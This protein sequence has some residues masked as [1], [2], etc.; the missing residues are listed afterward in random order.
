MTR[1][2]CL[3]FVLVTAAG[4]T[5]SAQSLYLPN[6]ASGVGVAGGVAANEDALALAVQAGYSYRTFIDGGVF[7]RRYAYDNT[8]SLSVSSIGVEPYATVHLLRQSDTVPLSLAATASYEK[9]FFTVQND[10]SGVSIDGWA[11]FVGGYAY[12]HFD[13]RGPWSLTPQVTVGFEHAHT[14][15]GVGLIGPDPYTDS[16]AF[17]LAGNLGYLDRG[18]RIWLANP[19]LSFDDRHATFGLNVGATFPIRRR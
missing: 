1:L 12:R 8:G 16:L 10:T 17:Q 14:T 4:A 18:G 13:L 6:G 19:F 2:A 9:Q 5:A 11:M 3:T 7:V 15:G